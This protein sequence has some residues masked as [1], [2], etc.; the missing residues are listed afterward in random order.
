MLSHSGD[1]NSEEHGVIQLCGVKIDT[2]HTL[3]PAFRKW[4]KWIVTSHSLCGV[5]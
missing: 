5:Q 1:C 4:A 3:T 2:R